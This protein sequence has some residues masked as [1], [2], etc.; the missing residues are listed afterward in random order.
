MLKLYKEL[1][2]Y[3]PGQKK[4]AFIAMILA[5]ISVFMIMASY[6]C[7]WKVFEEMLVKEA[8]YRALNYGIAVIVFMVLKAV[9]LLTGMFSSHYVAFKLEYGMR[10]VGLDKLMEASFSFFDKNNSGQI[11]RILDDNASDTHKTVAHLIP[12]HIVAILTP[13]LMI[14]MTFYIDFRLG[15]LL[16]LT[17]VIGVLLFKSMSG[18]GT[19]F[20][21]KYTR[22]LEEMSS[23]TVEYIRG[24]QVI[25][26]F[27][28][29]VQYYKNLIDSINNYKK[30]VYQ[31]SLNCMNPYVL[32]L[33]VF[34]SFY[35]VSIP[36]AIIFIS[37]GE[38]ALFILAKVVFF[39]VFS[40]VLLTSFI[41][42]MK[43][44][45]D[46]FNAQNSVDKLKGLMTEMDQE[47]IVYGDRTRFDHFT[48]EF[49]DVDFKYED[50]YVLNHFNL[51]LEGN[52]TYALVGPSG[53]GKSTIAKLISGFYPIHGGVI[54]IGDKDIQSYEMSVLQ[55]NIAFVFQNTSLFKLSIY[56]NVKLG[57]PSADKSEIM[58]ALK[59]ASCESILDK[60]PER[61]NT[62][63]GSKGVYLSG[64]EVQRVAIARAILKAANII[65][66][67][68]ASAAADPENEYELQRAFSQLIRNKTVIMIAHRLSS[69]TNADE[70]IFVENGA[71]VEK[72]SHQELMSSKGRYEKL[73]NLYCLANEWRIR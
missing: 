21:E 41:G 18:A 20:M 30:F 37:R 17:T 32:F 58:E 25:K 42:I 53:G 48:I 72:G 3:V 7:L 34:N 31:H 9:I 50:Q 54:T 44:S 49:R 63:V 60:F 55:K 10:K 15:I 73:Y 38:P 56:E 8:Y 69:I 40:E 45:T 66:M 26:I 59:N 12:D 1:F 23:A 29:T 27:G 33:V 4:W 24:M 5:G 67:D 47:K 52:K 64:G 62:V 6:W 14:S 46:N 39:A 65:I 61:E 13:L 2:E 28:I 57:R 22:S 70:I 19:K 36:F 43:M 16:I 11:R 68:E 35:A 51:K 71:I